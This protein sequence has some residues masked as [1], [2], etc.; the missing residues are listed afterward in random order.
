MIQV[1]SC[2][3]QTTF[4]PETEEDKEIL[5]KFYKQLDK[6]SFSAKIELINESDIVITDSTW[7]DE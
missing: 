7:M 1:A 5:Q 2:S 3:Y 6:R 4:I